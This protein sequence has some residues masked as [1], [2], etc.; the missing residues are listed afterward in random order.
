[1][2]E[3]HLSNAGSRDLYNLFLCICRDKGGLNERST[4]WTM[5][6]SCTAALEYKAGT[7]FLL[8]EACEE[9]QTG[10]GAP[11]KPRP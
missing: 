5:R 6:T 1:M 7:A 11:T 4:V 2:T 9:P 3:A 8:K 10:R